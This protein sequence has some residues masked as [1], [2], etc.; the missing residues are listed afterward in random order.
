MAASTSGRAFFNVEARDFD[1]P[2]AELV[3]FVTAAGASLCKAKGC[4]VII[5]A[6]LHR[7]SS[8]LLHSRLEP[9][10]HPMVS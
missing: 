9:F 6:R 1:V 7:D 10:L 3:I 5:A 2:A 4:A 8:F